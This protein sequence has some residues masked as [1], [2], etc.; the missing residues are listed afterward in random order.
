MPGRRGS[1][2]LRLLVAR[3]VL[4]AALIAA[5][6]IAA[7]TKVIDPYF[8]SLPSKLARTVAGWFVSGFIYPH[9]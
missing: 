8:V 5:W 6:E 3:A 7:R 4:F 1:E 9:I 2:R